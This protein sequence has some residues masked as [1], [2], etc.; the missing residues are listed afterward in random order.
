MKKLFLPLIIAIAIVVTGCGDRFAI[1]QSH[2]FMEMSSS[3]TFGPVQHGAFAGRMDE[4]ATGTICTKVIS[5]RTS[6]ILLEIS[7]EYW[8]GESKADLAMKLNITVQPKKDRESLIEMVMKGEPTVHDDRLH[9]YTP[10]A[11]A[12]IQITKRTVNAVRGALNAHKYDGGYMT[13]EQIN[14]NTEYVTANILFPAVKKILSKS[15]FTLTSVDIETIDLP[16]EVKDRKINLAAQVDA[17]AL[18]M[19]KLANDLLAAK[20]TANLQTIATLRDLGRD[21]LVAECMTQ[22]M[23]TMQYIT[24]MQT[25]AE[26][27]CGATFIPPN[28]EALPI[29]PCEFT[30]DT[31][32][33]KLEERAARD[34]VL[35]EY[36]EGK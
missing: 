24:A 21:Q 36:E 25:C 30:A 18:R 26:N 20:A 14:D 4:C 17:Q 16:S 2:S 27:S 15:A 33:A 5:V 22:Q 6:P 9:E 12:E 28:V 1:P 35:A 31:L 8:I 11:L 10:D 32:R 23:V 3:G 29:T 34:A 7:G 19:N 13:V